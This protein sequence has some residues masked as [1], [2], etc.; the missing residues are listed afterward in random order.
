LEGY[1]SSVLQVLLFGLLL[2]MGILARKLNIFDN[3][4]HRQITNI[5]LNFTFPALLISFALIPFS[6]E[7][8]KYA[9]VLLLVGFLVTIGCFVIALLFSKF[10]SKDR[11]IRYLF[12]FLMTFRNAGFVGV[13]VCLALFGKEAALLGALFIIPHDI[14]MWSLGVWMLK[15]GAG[16]IEKL[17]FKNFFTLPSLFAILGILIYSLPFHDYPKFVINLVT[18]IGSPTI[19]LALML[20]GSQLFITKP[21]FT[22]HKRALAILLILKM[23]VI[24]IIIFFLLKAINFNPV[25]AKVVVVISAMPPPSLSPVLSAEFNINPKFAGTATV[26]LTIGMLATLPLVLLFLHI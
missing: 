10:V 16:R 12:I 8:F 22:I 20:L 11:E 18:Y 19:F 1:I 6:A 15:K 26:G 2:G 25:A 3:T 7:I 23:L 24:P 14:I 9:F 21:D 5:I 4:G 17:S 13:P